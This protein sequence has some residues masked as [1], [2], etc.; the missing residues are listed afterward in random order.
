MT[1]ANHWNIVAES[2]NYMDDETSVGEFIFKLMM[3]KSVI[4]TR[5]KYTHLREN[6]TNL[7][8]YTSTVDSDFEN[9]NQYVNVNLDGLKERGERTYDLMINIFK[10]YQVASYGEFV[11]YIKT[12]R[13]QYDDEY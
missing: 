3:Q 11:R 1:E 9:F 13:D 12:K 6:L 2:N 7:D 10:A 8:T 5:A 4:N